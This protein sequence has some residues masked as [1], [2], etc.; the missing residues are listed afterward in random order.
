MGAEDVADRLDDGHHGL[1]A[2]DQ[3]VGHPERR[4]VGQ[5]QRDERDVRAAD[6]LH[7]Q[8]RR[9]QHS[10]AGGDQVQRGGQVVDVTGEAPRLTSGGPGEGPGL[11]GEGPGLT[12]EGADERAI[13]TPEAVRS[14]W[15]GGAVSSL[16]VGVAGGGLAGSSPV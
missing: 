15:F 6:R 16:V 2:P 14:S 7:Q 3:A 12:G 11:T 4:P 5:V 10:P 1:L 9:R 13:S 8:A